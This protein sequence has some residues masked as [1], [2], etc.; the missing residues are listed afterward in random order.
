MSMLSVDPSISLPFFRSDSYCGFVG[1]PFLPIGLEYH[2]ERDKSTPAKS[3]GWGQFS[4]S[5]RVAVDPLRLDLPKFK[6]LP[7]KSSRFGYR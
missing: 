4:L 5:N 1:F 7:N 2:V 6:A 3:N